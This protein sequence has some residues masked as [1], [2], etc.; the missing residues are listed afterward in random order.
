MIVSALGLVWAA[1][2]GTRPHPDFETPRP[3]MRWLMISAAW[4]A[5]LVGTIVAVIP[6][7]SERATPSWVIPLLILLAVSG[8]V[9]GL[10]QETRYQRDALALP[11][12]AGLRRL[13]MVLGVL[14]ASLGAVLQVWFAL[15]W[16]PE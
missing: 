16:V 1:L 6:W 3:G 9:G 2:G 12:D 14:M 10:A 15:F 4:T 5:A 8:L 13:A 7:A 11:P